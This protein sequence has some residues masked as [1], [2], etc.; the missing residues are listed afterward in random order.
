MRQRLPEVEIMS[1]SAFLKRARFLLDE[2]VPKR[3]A[4]FLKRK[5][6]DAVL[7]PKGVVNGKLAELSKSERRV[8]IT[9]D[10]DFT[11]P[12][13][14]PKEKVFCVVWIRV[15]QSRPRA[16]IAAFS[17]LL[18]NRNKEEGF[19]GKLITLYEERFDVD[20]LATTVKL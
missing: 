12:V 10:S 14:F 2:N 18:K 4:G 9:N 8:L 17:L 5:G 6:F 20:L 15:A 16:L 11:D 1:S 3:L 7:A 13:P 19:E